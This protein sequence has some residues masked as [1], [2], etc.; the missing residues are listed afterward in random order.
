[1]LRADHR[2]TDLCSEGHVNGYTRRHLIF[3]R[4]QLPR[5]QPNSQ[6]ADAAAEHVDLLHSSLTAIVLPYACSHYTEL[7]DQPSSLQ[8]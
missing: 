4:C 3:A 8:S 6:A 1:M 5:E 2:S 7:P